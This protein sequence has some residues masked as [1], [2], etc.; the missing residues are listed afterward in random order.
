MDIGIGL[1]ATTPGVQGQ[2][3]LDWASRAETERFSSLGIID[4]L[5]YPSFEPLVTLAAVAGRTHHIRLMTTILIAPLR[6]AGMLAKQVSSLDALSGG[7][8]TLGLG[9]GGREDDFLVS[10]ASFHNRGRQFEEQLTLMNRLWSGLPGTE[11]E[12]IGPSP[13]KQGGP[14]L[15]IGGNTP[16]A[17]QRVGRWGNGV[18]LGGQPAQMLTL[19][20]IAATAWQERGRPGKPRL[21]GGMYYA[22][23][24]DAAEKADPYI[25]QFYA[26]AGKMA[27]VISSRL[28]NTPLKVKDA[29]NAYADIGVD[30][31]V[32]WPCIGNLDQIERLSALVH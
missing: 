30:E 5:V 22:L 1:P 16:I 23:G 32:L 15:L 10:P 25:R 14:E 12:Q 27:E 21:V 28:A 11:E 19:Y 8:L 29:I 31:I 2:F 9:V 17:L 7:R 26:F 24:P 6:G 13:T 3:L 18:I 4:R 20:N